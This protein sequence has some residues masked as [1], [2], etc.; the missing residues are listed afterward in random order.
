MKMLARSS[1]I[2]TQIIILTNAD[3]PFCQVTLQNDNP[4]GATISTDLL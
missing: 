2:T 3:A 1:I 4:Y